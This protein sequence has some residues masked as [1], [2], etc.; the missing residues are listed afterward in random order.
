MRDYRSTSTP[1]AYPPRTPNGPNKAQQ[2]DLEQNG[3]YCYAAAV[4]FVVHD[5]ST[6]RRT[7]EEARAGTQEPAVETIVRKLGG[8]G[9][10]SMPSGS[11][12]DAFEFVKDKTLSMEMHEMNSSDFEPAA[13][14][15]KTWWGRVV[16]FTQPASEIGHCIGIK[17]EGDNFAVYDAGKVKTSTMNHDQIILE[18][19]IKYGSN[20]VI[21]DVYKSRVPQPAF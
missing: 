6:V 13:L 11:I 1:T 16:G 20:V 14:E 12:E 9:A 7:I 19:S 18:G 21:H 10:L 3:P 15:G 17:S 4:L 8:D 5:I 2:D